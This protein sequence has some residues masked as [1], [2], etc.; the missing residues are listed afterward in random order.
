MT[1]PNTASFDSA[2]S[3]PVNNDNSISPSNKCKDGLSFGLTAAYLGDRS[4]ICALS[5]R[6]NA[7][8]R[9]NNYF[10]GHLEQIERHMNN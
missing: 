6:R 2:S 10:V 4:E 7:S 9:K 1:D 8:A 5:D 3:Y